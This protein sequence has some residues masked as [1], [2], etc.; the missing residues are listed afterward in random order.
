MAVERNPKSPVLLNTLGAAL[1]RADQL[2]EAVRQVNTA[3]KLRGD[4][5]TPLDWLFLAMAH[6]RLG[7][8]EE[9]KKWLDKAV[10]WIDNATQEKSRDAVALSLSWR[11]RLELQLLRGEAET[12]LRQA[13]PV[14]PE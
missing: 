10:Q 8:T 12:L 3:I 11:G 1:Y 14:P 13:A 6:H 7:H 2:N 5:D 9:A 4:V